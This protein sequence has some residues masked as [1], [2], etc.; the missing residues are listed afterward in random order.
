MKLCFYNFFILSVKKSLDSIW[1][2]HNRNHLL[3]TI[4]NRWFKDTAFTWKVK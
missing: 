1:S 4:I 3:F 2:Y